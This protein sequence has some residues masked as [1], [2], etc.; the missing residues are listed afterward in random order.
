[1]ILKPEVTK[2]MGE[3]ENYATKSRKAEELE[4]PGS[5]KKGAWQIFKNGDLLNLCVMN[6]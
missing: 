6:V 2:P 1:M 5:F 4:I 3:K